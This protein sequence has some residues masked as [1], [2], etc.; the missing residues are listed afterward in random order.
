[1]QTRKWIIR[2]ILGLLGLAA[3]AVIAVVGLI[4]YD[5]L[6]P[7]QTA[8]DFTNVTYS[9][10][11]G[12]TLSGYLAQPS[13]GQAEP[14]P[15]VLL[16]HE[17]YG[18]NGSIVEKADRLADQ[19]Y[20][21][22][23]PDAY[24]GQ[25]TRLVPRAI[26]LVLSTPQEQINADLDAAYA[27]LQGLPGVDPARSGGVGFCFGGS[28][29]MRL[30]VRQ[31]ELAATVIFYGSGLITDPQDLGALGQNGPVL[32]IFGEEDASIPLDEVQAFQDA[33][34]SR[35]VP[36]EVTVYPGVG[37][38][39]VSSEALDEPGPAQQ[40]WEQMLAFLDTTLKQPGTT[41][42]GESLLAQ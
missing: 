17:F 4:A 1:M 42:L 31:P 19:G 30:G 13:G 34:A 26:W 18:L 3:L 28:Q 21:V 11:N 12:I 25:T 14:G 5:S 10:P 9:G 39:F 38:A 40:A 35:Q 22:L 41:T 29:I 20:T 6:F 33:L 27:Y 24:R 2:I 8:A 15:A 16:V 7:A 32:G 36:H 37:H 23:A